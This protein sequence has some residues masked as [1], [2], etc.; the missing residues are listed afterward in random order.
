L[1]EISLEQIQA[2]FRLPRK[3][4]AASL[5][6]KCI[7]SFNNACKALGVQH[8]QSHRASRSYWTKEEDKK[9]EEGVALWGVKDWTVIAQE[10]PGRL[11]RHVRDRWMNKVDP[12]LKRGMWTAEEDKRLNDLYATHGRS[13]T[14]IAALLGGR[15]PNQVGGHWEHLQMIKATCE[16]TEAMSGGLF[17]RLA[18]VEVQ[19]HTYVSD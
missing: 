3:D 17:S 7:K 10:L 13:W 8:W 9:V 4:A 2:R 6:F 14:K 15:P 19:V 1:C 11:G 16:R 18:D 12:A 5:G